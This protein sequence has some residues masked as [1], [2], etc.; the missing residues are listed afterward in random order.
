MLGTGESAVSLPDKISAF[1]ELIL[2]VEK[3]YN[4][5]INM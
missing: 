3:I 5:Q 4:K 1:I 2:L